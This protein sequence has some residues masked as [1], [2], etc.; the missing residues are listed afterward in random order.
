MFLNYF[1]QHLFKQFRYG[2]YM[3]NV[4]QQEGKNPYEAF[5]NKE[6]TLEEFAMLIGVEPHLVVLHLKELIQE[7]EDQVK[8]SPSLALYELAEEVYCEAKQLDLEDPKE[9]LYTK[10]HV[11]EGIRKTAKTIDELKRIR[12]STVVIQNNMMQVNIAVVEQFLNKVT[13]YLCPKCQEKM[14]EKYEELVPVTNK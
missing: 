1:F 13:P 12:Q 2:D 4:L 7:Y 14:L 3:L 10:L 8:F 11:L 5:Y 9:R 6:I